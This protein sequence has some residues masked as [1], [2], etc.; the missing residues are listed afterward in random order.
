MNNK[1]FT[2]F[3]EWFKPFKIGFDVLDLIDIINKY[4]IPQKTAKAL[5][6]FYCGRPL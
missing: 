6:N 3:P 4:N 5:I 1:K 2:D